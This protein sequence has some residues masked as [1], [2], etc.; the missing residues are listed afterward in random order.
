MWLRP[1]ICS[2]EHA[3]KIHQSAILGKLVIESALYAFVQGL[4][5]GLSVV[6]DEPGKQPE[7]LIPFLPLSMCK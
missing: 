3:T 4:T 1:V 5:P 7:E 6:V 2:N